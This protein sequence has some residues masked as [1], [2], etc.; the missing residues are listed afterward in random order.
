MLRVISCSIFH[1]PQVV[2][3]V[4]K[5]SKLLIEFLYFFS[6]LLD[7]DFLD[8]FYAT[9]HQ[10]VDQ[11]IAFE[12]KYVVILFRIFYIVLRFS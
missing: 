7:R 6:R 11:K 1:V 12:F 8:L 10:L 3:H 5:C 9:P 2:H 4:L